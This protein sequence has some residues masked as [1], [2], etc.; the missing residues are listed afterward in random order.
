MRSGGECRAAFNY[1]WQRGRNESNSFISTERTSYIKRSEDIIGSEGKM[2]ARIHFDLANQLYACHGAPLLRLYFDHHR[3]H[4][5]A[6]F[7]LGEKI[8]SNPIAQV[9]ADVLWI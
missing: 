1:N 7:S 2:E 9:V 6:P 5:R 4:H 8:L 3:K